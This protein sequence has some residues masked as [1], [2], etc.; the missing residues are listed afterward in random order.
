MTGMNMI[1]KIRKTSTRVK[2]SPLLLTRFLLPI[3]TPSLPP[4]DA[5]ASPLFSF[6]LALASPPRAS[7]ATGPLRMRSIPLPVVLASPPPPCARTVPLQIPSLK[8]QVKQINHKNHRP[9]WEARHRRSSGSNRLAHAVGD[10]LPEKNLT[11]QE[12]GMKSIR[13]SGNVYPLYPTKVMVL[14]PYSYATEEILCCLNK[15]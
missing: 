1:G 10:F 8:K 3:R 12:R 13:L 7:C 4:P 9:R 6:A 14:L 2:P 15:G 11:K 5:V